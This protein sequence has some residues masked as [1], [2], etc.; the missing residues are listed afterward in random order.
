[1][2]LP[3]NPHDF[4]EQKDQLWLIAPD[5]MEQMMTS[6]E[7]D[8]QIPKEFCQIAE[9]V[10]FTAIQSNPGSEEL[11][12][13]PKGGWQIKISDQALKTALT[14][15]FL[16]VAL[17]GLG[18]TMLPGYVLP[19][20]LPLLFDIEK[21]R[22]SR[23]ENELLIELTR[24]ESVHQTPQNPKNLYALLSK[25]N[26]IQIPYLDFLD[27]LDKLE[28]AGFARPT[29]QDRVLLSNPN[30]AQFKLSIL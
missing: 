10:F 3:I 25:E 1:M 6:I 4:L 12:M 5:G 16:S 2:T 20:V 22:L 7:Q 28:K 24:W 14:M 9:E 11:H 13:L 29:D 27:F 30:F 23:K 15:T 8:F 26:Q 21:V 19:A 18:F 17:G